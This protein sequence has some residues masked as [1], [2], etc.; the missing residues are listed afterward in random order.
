METLGARIRDLRIAKG[1][2]QEELADR[3]EVS[4]R[5]LRRYERNE[6]APDSFVLARLAQELETSADGLLGL[7]DAGEARREYHRLRES[8]RAGDGEYYWLYAGGGRIG[9]HRRP[10]GTDRDGNTVYELSPVPPRV[11]DGL[12]RAVFTRPLVV[13]REEEAQLFRLFGGEAIVRAD[14][15]HRLFPEA[16]APALDPPEDLQRREALEGLAE[17][18]FFLL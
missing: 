7:P 4:G 14:L 8:V 3:I 5:T 13:E 15:C 11:A 6:K 18:R 1:L 17:W 10:S 16:S 2:T 9:G 12:C